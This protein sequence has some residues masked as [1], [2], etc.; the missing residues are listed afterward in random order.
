MNNSQH[1]NITVPNITF[2]NKW[3]IGLSIIFFVI[4]AVLNSAAGFSIVT[5]GGLSK[6]LFF[7]GHLYELITYPFMTAP[8]GLMGFVFNCILLWFIGSELERIWGFR[9]YL[10]FIIT[11]VIGGGIFFLAITSTFFS[12]MSGIALTNIMG[13]TN[14]LLIAYAIIFPNNIFHFFLI[15]PMK[16]KYFC[17]ILIAIQLYIGMTSPHGALAWGHLGAMFSGV[18]YMV[19]VSSP[20]LKSFL[21]RA[22]DKK[23]YKMR[24]KFTLIK[25]SKDKDKGP[26]Y[27]Q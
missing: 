6:E 26:K 20:Q 13:I 7:K 9:R 5:F 19:V 24:Q 25:G 1:R 27:W 21:N 4:N 18:I 3:L 14:S 8:G 15:F 2:L 10:Y 22:K 23:S 12:G 16:A 17:G 11:T